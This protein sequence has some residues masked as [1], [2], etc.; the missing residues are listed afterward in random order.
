MRTQEPDPLRQQPRPFAQDEPA[1]R[2]MARARHKP[3]A[4]SFERRRRQLQKIC[5]RLALA[6]FDRTLY[7]CVEQVGHRAQPLEARAARQDSNEEAH[8]GIPR[9][10]PR[11]CRLPI[12]MP[13]FH[14]LGPE[15]T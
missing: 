10:S 5:R 7:R 4:L 11:S 13:V 1:R 3:P 6:R 9:G 12:S 2:Q 14:R 8:S 15:P